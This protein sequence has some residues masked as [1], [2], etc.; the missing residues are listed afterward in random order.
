MRVVQADV[1]SGEDRYRH[2][3]QKLAAAVLDVYHGRQNGAL[4]AERKPSDEAVLL[5]R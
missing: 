1:V 5:T 2:D 3:V 4:E